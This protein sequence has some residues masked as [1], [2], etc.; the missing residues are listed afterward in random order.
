MKRR[1]FVNAAPLPGERTRLLYG[2]HAIG[3]WVDAQPT[4]LLVVRHGRSLS[5]Q[6]EAIVAAAVS[7]GVRVEPTAES[8]LSASVGTARHQGL[9]AEVAP[10]PYVAQE[11]ILSCDSRQIV[12]VDHLQ[13]PRNLGAILRTAEAV[14]AGGVLLP[15]D[16]AVQVTGTVEVAAAG[17]A[18]RIPIGRV[19]NLGRALL[20]AHAHGFWTVG[21][22][23]RDG[24]DL[25]SADLPAQVA[26]V[27]GGETG[28]RPLV[29]RR[30]DWRV[31]VP[32]AGRAESLN[33]SVAAAVVLYE[34]FRR[35][36]TP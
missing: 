19:A 28:L 26:A 4:R 10:F 5:P 8:G 30:C 17:A 32:M 31:S 15:R 29:A 27:V 7:R 12:F 18:A 25:F 34:L 33:A 16:G 14:G 35:S 13:D 22:T 6:A 1:G 3:A 36:R 20:Q 24:V 21:L 11:R 9:V 23:P 2:L